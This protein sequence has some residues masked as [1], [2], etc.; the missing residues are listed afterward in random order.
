[1]FK[2]WFFD[3]DGTLCDTEAD[4]R[5]AW[6]ATIRELG[7]P[8]PRFDEIYRNGP[9]I[10]VMTERFF[11]GEATVELKAAV[12]A[13]FKRNYDA[14]RYPNS[15]LYPWITPWLDALAAAG[16]TV[17]VASNKRIR[18]LDLFV[19]KFSWRNR[20]DGVWAPD[21]YAGVKMS[22]AEFLAHAC[23]VR[24]WDPADAVMVGDTRGDVEAARAAGMRAVGVTW[25]Y[26]EPG[27]VDEADLVLTP[28]SFAGGK[29]P[30]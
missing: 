2:H 5:G 17:S 22:K 26:G 10:D 21:L 25:G 1:L 12:R 15:R 3:F 18:A 7:K 9:S 8:C 4:I 30:V 20:I 24:G 19:E 14:A 23:I 28:D 11:P 27:E 6:L 29:Y 13:G 16:C